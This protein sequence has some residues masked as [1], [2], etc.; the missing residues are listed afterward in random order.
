MLSD[1]HPVVRR[2][3]RNIL[4]STNQFEVCGEAGDGS[5]TLELTMSLRPDILIADISMPPPNG[6][7]VA[8][9]LHEILP[10]TKIEMA[11]EIFD[12]DEFAHCCA[13]PQSL[14]TGCEWSD[15]FLRNCLAVFM[16]DEE[17]RG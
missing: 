17:S 5:E 7:E 11:V 13:G 12:A 10:E 15:L 4:E 8:A 14:T 9:R 2:G 1:D 6:L 3:L 16:R